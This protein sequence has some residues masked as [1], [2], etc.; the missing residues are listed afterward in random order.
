M[1]LYILILATVFFS[2][3]VK[4]E[5]YSNINYAQKQAQEFCDQAQ[6]NPKL[7]ESLRVGNKIMCRVNK[8]DNN[9][10]LSS[11]D[12]IQ[13]FVRIPYSECRKQLEENSCIAKEYCSWT[14][15]YSDPYNIRFHMG[16]D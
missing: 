9:K 16:Q 1:R 15:D 5:C 11:S 10:C 2:S 13:T 6:G 12:G 3:C 14:F 8:Q 7:C 4:F